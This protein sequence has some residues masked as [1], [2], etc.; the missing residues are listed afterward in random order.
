MLSDI[1]FQNSVLWLFVFYIAFSLIRPANWH[2]TTYLSSNRSTK[3]P[4]TSKRITNIIEHMTYEVF[5]YTARGLYEEHKF[6]FT[7]LLTLKIDIQ[8]NRVKH[9]E[10]LTLIKGL[11]YRM[12]LN[13]ARTLLQKI[14]ELWLCL[15]AKLL[16]AFEREKSVKWKNACTYFQ[17]YC[18]KKQLQKSSKKN[19]D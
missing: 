14:C 8:R 6:L 1:K 2:S 16:L 7:L 9:E 11:N 18:T 13:R 4:I 15:L 17:A 19:K 10:F 3:S 12:V 5:K